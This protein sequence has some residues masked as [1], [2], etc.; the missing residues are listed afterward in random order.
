[1]NRTLGKATILALTLTLCL[2]TLASAAAPERA[3]VIRVLK[4]SGELDMVRVVIDRMKTVARERYAEA[5]PEYARQV[6]EIIDSSMDAELEESLPKLADMMAEA[7]LPHLTQEDVEVLL[8]FYSSDTWQKL[9]KKRP[10]ISREGMI[11]ARGWA[12][13]FA[14]QADKRIRKRLEEEGLVE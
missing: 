1:M 9:K 7:W 10:E 3:D 4:L 2:A 11:L 5:A 13:V 6:S 12:N 14:Q 8:D